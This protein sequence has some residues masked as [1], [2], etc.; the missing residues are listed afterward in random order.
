MLKKVLL[1]GFLLV[2]VGAA[3]VYYVVGGVDIVVTA[4]GC[5]AVHPPVALPLTWRATPDGGVAHVPPLTVHV[6][7]SVRQGHETLTLTGPGGLTTP[8][9]IG[10]NVVS[11]AFDGTPLYQRAPGRSPA[12]TTLDLGRVSQ[13]RLVL[14]C[15]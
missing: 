9:A 8:F 6:D 3:I 14:L 1:R 5:G 15:R 12:S 4:T 7:A 13:H 11:V 2:V 10:S